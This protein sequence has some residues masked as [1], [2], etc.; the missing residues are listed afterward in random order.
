M[1]ALGINLGFLLF[2]V[3]NVAIIYVA[4]RA[5]LWG[6]FVELLEK[7]RETIERG[8]EDA[9]IASEAR[10]NAEA[11]A[12]GIINQARAEA[13]KIVAEARER[14]EEAV[15]EIQQEATRE[16]EEIRAEARRQAESERDQLLADM[17]SQVVSLAIAAA[18]R[19]IGESM[20]EKKQEA[21]VNDFFSAAPA[22]VKNLGNEV[23]VISALPLTDKEI[24]RIKKETGANT[25]TTRVDPN[26]LGGLILRSGDKVVDGSVR[27]SLNDLRGRL[28]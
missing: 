24:E 25:V 6:K 1:E 19:L 16:A 13:Q 12:Q 11:E 8:L 20:D 10:A 7:R 2:Q 5:G 21:I 23:E 3:F 22:N 4:L 14:A 18:N 26:I 28:Q 17:R 9:R 15:K 27:T